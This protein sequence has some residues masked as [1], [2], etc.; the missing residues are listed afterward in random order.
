MDK[1]KA[2]DYIA[3]FLEGKGVDTVFGYIG[4][5][6]THLADSLYKAQGIRFIQTYHE[7]TAAI[8]AEGY[9]IE[10]GKIGVAISTSGP[11][12]TNMMTGIAD[13][14]YDSVPAIYITGQV[15]T[16]EYKYGKPIRQQGFQE[17]PVVEL[18][19]PIT[20]YAKLIDNA[21]DIPYELEK[22]YH[23][24]TSGR[25]G[26][27]VLDIPLNIQRSV[28]EPQKCRTYQEEHQTAASIEMQDIQ[29]VQD[30]LAKAKCPMLLCGGGCQDSS[31]KTEIKHFLEAT[32]IPAVVS[33]MGRGSVDESYPFYAG[34]VGSYGNRC[35]NMAISQADLLLAVGSR[36]DTRQTGARIDA[37]IPES[38]II[39]VDIDQDE[40]ECNRLG[41][42]IKI[43]AEASLFLSALNSECAGLPDLRVW[44]ELIG[45]C[46]NEYSQK[47]EVERFVKNKAPYLFIGYVNS[48]MK[49]NDIVCTDVG[50]NQMWAAQ[51]L[52]LENG[53]KFLTSGGLAPMGYSM[54]AAIG[55]AFRSP[56]KTIFSLVGDGG[57]HMSSQSLPVI[58]QYRLPVKVCV[59]NNRTL[60]MITQFQNLYFDG[61]LAGSAPDGGYLSPDIEK[62][63]EAY[64]LNY[65]RITV[66]D[67]SNTELKRRIISE[68]TC[69]VEFVIEGMT[70]VSPKLEYD[71]PIYNPSP[72]LSDEELKKTGFSFLN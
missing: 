1:I 55:C 64:G 29:M 45:K 39:H 36:L 52:R 15:N 51:T 27:V 61:R 33:L 48:M 50:Q 63:A 58:S 21:E 37:F 17:M 14:Y 25:K 30:A 11:G 49:E 13:A 24:A 66:N 12:A 7:Q 44:Q 47:R 67:L 18:V 32:G 41:N 69:V 53:Q 62:T 56:E 2:S 59:F 23:I 42:R 46:R 31:C 22:A 70:T 57:F 10:S 72:Q 20:K 6:I 35:A 68:K 60:G 19:K 71:K 5:M 28:I 9:A 38:T 8:A 54:P 3:D 4:G 65:Y 16:Y 26:P 40:L 34:M 43:K